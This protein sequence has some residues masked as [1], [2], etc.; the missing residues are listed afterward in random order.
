MSNLDTTDEHDIEGLKYSNLKCYSSWPDCEMDDTR[1]WTA[2]YKQMKLF[3]T[4]GRILYIFMFLLAISL[5]AMVAGTMITNARNSKIMTA[6]SRAG[7]VS[8]R[9]SHADLDVQRAMLTVSTHLLC[10]SQA[11][12]GYR[13][14]KESR[15]N[16]KT[17]LLIR[18]LRKVKV[19]TGLVSRHYSYPNSF[20]QRASMLDEFRFADCDQVGNEVARLWK[21]ELARIKEDSRTRRAEKGSGS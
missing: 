14:V 1:N 13:I 12:S 8:K 20:T 10:H 21:E 15:T 11:D 6:E 7:S 4:Q 16:N 18:S 2:W 3:C 5:L 17:W 19:Q 9:C